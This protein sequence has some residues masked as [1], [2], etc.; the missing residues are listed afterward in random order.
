MKDARYI[1]P[2]GIRPVLVKT[3]VEILCWGVRNMKRYQLAQVTSPSAM[4][5]I[6]GYTIETNVIKNTKKNPNFT[7]NAFY[8]EIVSICYFHVIFPYVKPFSDLRFYLNSLLKMMGVILQY[9]THYK[10][11]VDLSS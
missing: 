9:V 5:E 4:I 8:K 11:Q 10:P 3:G 1:V 2:N 7:K 6:G